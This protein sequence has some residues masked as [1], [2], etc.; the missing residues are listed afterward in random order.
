MWIRLR[1][2]VDGKERK[3]RERFGKEGEEGRLGKGWWK[4][5]VKRG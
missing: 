1:V 5:G 4:V 2:V 3:E